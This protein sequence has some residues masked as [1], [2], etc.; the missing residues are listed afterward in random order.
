MND[1]VPIGIDGYYAL[2]FKNN[3]CK[4]EFDIQTKFST[5][6]RVISVRKVGSENGIVFV[7]YKKQSE[8]NACFAALRN[9]HV[10]RVEIPRRTKGKGDRKGSKRNKQQQRGPIHNQ[11]YRTYSGVPEQDLHGGRKP[12]VHSEPQSRTKDIRRGQNIKYE[13]KTVTQLGGPNRRK[14]PRKDKPVTVERGWSSPNTQHITAPN[15][16]HINVQHTGSHSKSRRGKMG[17]ASEDYFQGWPPLKQDRRHS[18]RKHSSVSEDEETVY[19][20]PEPCAEPAVAAEL[21]PWEESDDNYEQPVMSPSQAEADD[22]SHLVEDEGACSLSILNKQNTE[23]ASSPVRTDYGGWPPPS[24][25]GEGVVVKTEPP[26]GNVDELE[27]LKFLTLGTPGPR[28]ESYE[29]FGGLEKCWSRTPPWEPSNETQNPVR[30]SSASGYGICDLSS[31][32]LCQHHLVAYGTAHTLVNL[33]QARAVVFPS[34]YYSA[35]HSFYE[36]EEH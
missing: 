20:S 30:S 33:D 36:E 31:S 22:A 5:F 16:Q 12:Y 28:A 25:H 24:P 17:G 7:R 18:R 35:C 27:R 2:C 13:E 23:T 15:T 26:A 3:K 19:G 29:P 14:D 1:S 32:V 6:G 9:D 10:Y 34:D 8:A 11:P 4:T 21:S